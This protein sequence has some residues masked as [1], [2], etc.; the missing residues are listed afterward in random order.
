MY[1][2]R[3]DQFVKLEKIDQILSIHFKTMLKLRFKK[4]V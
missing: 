1:I 4:S 2:E 3:T